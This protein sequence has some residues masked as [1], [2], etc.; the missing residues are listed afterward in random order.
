MDKQTIIAQVKKFS[1]NCST[2]GFK[3]NFCALVPEMENYDETSYILQ[4]SSPTFDNQPCSTVFDNVVPILFQSSTPEVREK[5]Y[6]LDI[7]DGKGEVHCKFDDLIFE[8]EIGYNHLTM[9]LS[10][11]KG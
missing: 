3:L 6:R 7:Y 10:K 9:Q 4:I 5:I 1:Q 11:L 8:N 2:K